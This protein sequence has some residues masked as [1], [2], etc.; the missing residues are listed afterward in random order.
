MAGL[1]RK[2]L[3]DSHMLTLILVNHVQL[4]GLLRQSHGVEH[5]EMFYDRQRLHS[6][7]GYRSPC[8]FLNE[9]RRQQ[10]LEKRVT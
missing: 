4:D 3:T 8:Q 2:W 10:E 1:A 5:I 6:T 7:L 9:W